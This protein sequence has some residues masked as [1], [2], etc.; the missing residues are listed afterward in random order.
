MSFDTQGYLSNDTNV[1]RV[2]KRRKFTQYFDIVE[3]VNAFCEN[4]KYQ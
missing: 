3:Y 2:E 4:I 1:F